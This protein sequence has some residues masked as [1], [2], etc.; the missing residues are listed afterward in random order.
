M[1]FMKTKLLRKV[2]K[3][4]SIV[5]EK[6][7]TYF[8]DVINGTWD[9]VQLIDKDFAYRQTTVFVS[10]KPKSNGKVF[11][12]KEEAFQYLHDVLT[13]WILKDYAHLG[14]RR[15]KTRNIREKLWYNG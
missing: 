15:N 7:S 6:N 4:Y 5:F 11:E 9:F 1:N 2:R 8:K 10:K 14:V 12:T 3:R 13:K